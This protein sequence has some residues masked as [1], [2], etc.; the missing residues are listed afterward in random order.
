MQTDTETVH[1]VGWLWVSCRHSLGQ[2]AYAHVR[3]ASAMTSRIKNH[4]LSA[5]SETPG[6]QHLGITSRG[7]TATNASASNPCTDCASSLPLPGSVRA[8]ITFPSAERLISAPSFSGSP[9][10]PVDF[11]RSLPAKSMRSS[12]DDVCTEHEAPQHRR[13][14]R[15]APPQRG[16]E[17]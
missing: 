10:A 1:R 7:I 8:F 16:I 4:V 11:W 2:S 5:I 6:T 15:A 14:W 17:N 9:D 12:L 13:P 3:I